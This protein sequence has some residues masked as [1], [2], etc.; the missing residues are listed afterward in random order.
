MVDHDTLIDTLCDEAAPVRRVA[1]AWRRALG[2]TPVALGVGWLMTQLLHRASTD[3]TGPLAGVAAAN[4]LLSLGL[5]IAALTAALSVSVPG[6][7]ARASG[8][9]VACLAMWLG[10]AVYSIGIARH[11]V[12]QLGH[13]SYCFT[14]VLVAGAPMIAVTV[15]ALRR[16]RSLHPVRSLTFAGAGA[17]FLSFGLLAFCHPIAMSAMDF[18]GHLAAGILL[19]ALTIAI[20]RKAIAA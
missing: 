4:I 18:A 1:P 13:G 15:L 11:P 16:T 2:W 7:V 12:G 17:A 5:G 8:W 14:F 9:F 10:L 20:G 3:W 19:G 6:R